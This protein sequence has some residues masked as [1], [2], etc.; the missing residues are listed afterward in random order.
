MEEV[1]PD[2]VQPQL[3]N[4]R[5]EW[6]WVRPGIEE[7]LHANPDVNTLPED[8]YHACKA[9][10]AHLW[11]APEYFVITTFETDTDNGDRVFLLWFAWSRERGGKHSMT[12]NSFFEEVARSQGCAGIEIQT[13]HQPL[14]DYSVGQ[15]GYHVRTQILRKDLM[16]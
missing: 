15:L 3:A 2:V 14:I 7:L 12:A 1:K 11:V 6:H 4:I 13:N 10:N 5:E 8:V 9:G 16:E